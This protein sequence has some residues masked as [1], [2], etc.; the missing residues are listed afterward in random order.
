MFFFLVLAFVVVDEMSVERRDTTISTAPES[1]EL[2][3]ALASALFSAL[4]DLRLRSRV[5]EG[6]GMEEGIW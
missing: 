3:G 1:L 5:G 4:L 6:G 2:T